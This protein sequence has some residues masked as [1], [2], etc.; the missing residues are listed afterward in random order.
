MSNAVTPTEI[1]EDGLWPPQ[2]MASTSQLPMSAPEYQRYGRQMVLPSFGSLSS[3]LA[4]RS[5][6]VLVIGGGGL[7]C[8]AVQSL[9]S[10]GVGLITAVDHDVVERSNLARQMLHT[11]ERIGMNKAKSI[12]VAVRQLNPHVRVEAVTEALT[13]SNAVQLVG[14]HDLVLDCTDNPL[15]RYLINDAAVLTGKTVVSGA[16]QGTEGQLVVLNKSLGISGQRGPCFRCLFPH[17]PRPQDVTD[18]EDGG[19]LGTT[20]ALVGTLQANETIKL[21]TGMGSST[22]DEQQQQQAVESGSPPRSTMLLISLL[23]PLQ[24][25]RTIKMRGR[26]SD[27]R[28]CGDDAVVHERGLRKIVDLGSED[29][30]AFC[31]L[32]PRD[33]TSDSAEDSIE[34]R[35]QA[36]TVDALCKQGTPPPVIVD[37]RTEAEY[38]IVKLPRTL[39]E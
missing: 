15:T 35:L 30:V 4:L 20:T 17:A 7:G 11:E 13:T 22:D 25:F 14:A 38:G 26:R 19:V 18:C 28:I 29:Y 6:R 21:L 36:M 34:D 12:Q 8:P 3:Q 2:P 24:P 33:A 39:S 23:E 31:G 16:A 5:S 37:V 9:A 1:D 32:A 27:C 10:C